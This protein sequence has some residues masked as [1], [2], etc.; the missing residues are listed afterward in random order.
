MLLF[1]FILRFAIHLSKAQPRSQGFSLNTID[2]LP[3]IQSWN[4][5]GQERIALSR[6]GGYSLNWAI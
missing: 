5:T 4:S 1:S 6:G 2:I 3:T